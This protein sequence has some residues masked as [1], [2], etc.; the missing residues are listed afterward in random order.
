LIDQIN[1]SVELIGVELI[2]D[3]SG[4][5][6]S[7]FFKFGADIRDARLFENLAMR[8]WEWDD[9]RYFDL[10]LPSLCSF[11]VGRQCLIVGGCVSLELLG[12]DGS[13][14]EGLGVVRYWDG[15]G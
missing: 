14:F 3:N 9:L 8:A 11:V 4:S 12:G 13:G 7:K 5:Q 1:F 10:V 2:V 15:E 6:G